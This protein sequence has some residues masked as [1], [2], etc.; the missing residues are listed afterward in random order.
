MF[1][2]G[3]MEI[4]LL[5]TVV[6]KLYLKIRIKTVSF[7][8]RK[9]KFRIGIFNLYLPSLHTLPY[10]MRLYPRYDKF[11]PHF[12]RYLEDGAVV[13]DVGANVGDTLALMASENPRLSYFAI[14]GSE[15]FFHYLELNTRRMREQ[16]RDLNIKIENALIGNTL[17][18]FS[19]QEFQGTAS[20]RPDIKKNSKLI[21]LDELFSVRESVD[22]NLI[23][24]DTD[25]FDFLVIDN[26]LETI[27]RETPSLFFELQIDFSWQM[28][29]YENSLSILNSIGY[30]NWTFFDNFGSTILSTQDFDIVVDL[31]RYLNLQKDHKNQRTIFH[32]DVLAYTQKDKGLV[33][34]IVKDYKVSLI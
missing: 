11:L 33:D 32:F 6:L 23:K 16:N 4:S 17:E 21:P 3:P 31:L 7:F 29:R 13:I 2:H 26:S 8:F 34:A 24:I 18:G 22:I 19:L 12:V 14:E 28:V 27:K 30:S 20:L 5:K 15:K 1:Y 25:G 9:I 10:F